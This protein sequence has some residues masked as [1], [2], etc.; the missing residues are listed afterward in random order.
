[1]TFRKNINKVKQ[2]NHLTPSGVSIAVSDKDLYCKDFILKFKARTNTIVFLKRVA[3]RV[4]KTSLLNQS[5]L[6]GK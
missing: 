6:A 4:F 1:M 2:I 3:Q 5:C